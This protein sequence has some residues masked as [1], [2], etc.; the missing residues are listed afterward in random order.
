MGTRT[1]ENVSTRFRGNFMN[2]IPKKLQCGPW[3]LRQPL[4]VHETICY[5]ISVRIFLSSSFDISQIRFSDHYILLE[6]WKGLG[7][8]YS[9]SPYRHIHID[10]PMR[11]H[12]SWY[13]DAGWRMTDPTLKLWDRA[14]QCYALR[15][16]RI[17]VIKFSVSNKTER[18]TPDQARVLIR[19][20]LKTIAINYSI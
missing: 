3:C 10:R 11:G 9:P 18:Y 15:I 19:L 17:A 2:L 8:R 12:Q 1:R 20:T 4:L 7:S 6:G 16:S 5:V 14:I 13:A